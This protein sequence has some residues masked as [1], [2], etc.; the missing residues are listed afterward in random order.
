MF[1]FCSFS[2]YANCRVIGNIIKEVDVF[3]PST[4]KTCFLP[5]LSFAKSVIIRFLPPVYP[6]TI[7]LLIRFYAQLLFIFPVPFL[8][9]VTHF[10][11]YILT[12]QV[13]TL[14]FS[15]LLLVNLLLAMPP[16]YDSFSSRSFFFF[17][18]TTRNNKTL[19]F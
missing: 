6:P 10:Q 12:Y 17:F 16:F 15:Q 14:L 7:F 8:L 4:S 13:T 19:T 2:H 1:V 18:Q 5:N 9:S 11:V 3:L